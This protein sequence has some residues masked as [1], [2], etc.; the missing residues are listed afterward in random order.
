MTGIFFAFF[1]PFY[2][3]NVRIKG[4]LFNAKGWAAVARQTWGKKG[5]FRYITPA[6]LDWFKPGFHPWDHDNH[7]FLEELEERLAY[8]LEQPEVA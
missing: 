6:W 1:I 3:H 4:G 7:H 8:V 2:V 5:I